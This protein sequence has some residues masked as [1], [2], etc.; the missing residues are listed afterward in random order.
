MDKW[1]SE[2]STLYNK[3]ENKE[4]HDNIEFYRNI[5]NLK[6]IRE[7]HMEHPLYEE[8]PELNGAISF[9]EIEKII[10]KLKINKSSG[11]D[12]IPNEVLKNHDVMLLLYNLFT[13]CFEFGIMPT[14]WLKAL[15]LPV[16]K[17]ASKDQNVPLNYRGI[18]LLS[19]VSKVF[20]GLI[21]NL[22]I[23]Y[24]ELGGLL[25]DE[26]GGFRTNRA[27]VDHLYT[28]SII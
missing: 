15:I 16:L 22:V 24:C 25:V 18:I 5:M 17:S 28:I 3:P 6:Q 1:G 8:N 7:A 11:I 21:N 4:S 10:Y 2:F 23:N 27:Y 26:Q 13:I 14:I 12:Q 9:D 19:C 20:S